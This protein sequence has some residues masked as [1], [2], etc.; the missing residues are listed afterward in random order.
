[1]CISVFLAEGLVAA[2][3]DRF[4]LSVICSRDDWL[5]SEF[6]DRW[7]RLKDKYTGI[8][9][10]GSDGWH[11]FDVDCNFLPSMLTKATALSSLIPV[12]STAFTG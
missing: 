4:L 7:R 1:M 11:A 5:R 8:E 3:K 2:K 10:Y 9:V 6:D 12:I